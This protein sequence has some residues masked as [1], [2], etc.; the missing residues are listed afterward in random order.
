MVSNEKPV[1]GDSDK[2]VN[3]HKIPE[4]GNFWLE[5]DNKFD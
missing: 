4:T 1:D 2:W 5:L 3:E